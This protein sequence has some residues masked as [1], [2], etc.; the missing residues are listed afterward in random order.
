LSGPDVISA[1][2]A[3]HGVDPERLILEVTESRLMTDP[4]RAAGVL[5]RLAEI[6]VELSIDDFGTGYSSLAYLRRLS[7]DELKIDRTFVSDMC[8][9]DSSA[10]IV[11][12]IVQLAHNLGL[13][14]VAEGVE[15]EQTIQALGDLG[16]D[17]AQGYFVSRPLAAERVVPW[18]A[19]FSGERTGTRAA[20]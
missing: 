8:R 1:A 20:G 6:G 2:L 12:S 14:V 13:Q 11:R 18:L 15:D 10:V 9:S 7:V 17:M 3:R 5:R 19:A 4:D 16:C